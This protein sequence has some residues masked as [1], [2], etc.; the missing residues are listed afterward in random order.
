MVWGKASSEPHRE[1]KESGCVGKCP[2]KTL[3]GGLESEVDRLLYH[4][5]LGLRVIKKKKKKSLTRCTS[6]D[7]REGGER[8]L[9]RAN[10]TLTSK[11][12]LDDGLDFQVDVLQPSKVFPSSRARSREHRVQR[13]RRGLVSKAHRL[14]VS[15]NSRLESHKEEEEVANTATSSLA[16]SNGGP[17]HS[18]KN[19]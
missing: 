6:L 19:P 18:G 16:A 7:T 12:V 15:L 14:C 17:W 2:V 1:M 10:R 9:C 5:I 11:S 8:F 4:P 13:F 3:R